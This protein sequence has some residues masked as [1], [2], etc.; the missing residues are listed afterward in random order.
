MYQF[1]LITTDT[2]TKTNEEISGNTIPS[3]NQST[4]KYSPEEIFDKRGFVVVRGLLDSSFLSLAFRYVFHSYVNGHMY[5]GDNQVANSPSCYGDALMESLLEEHLE[6]IEYVTNLKL[7]PTYSY[8][9]IYQSGDTLGKHKDRPA[10]EV[11]ATINLGSTNNKIEWPINVENKDGCQ[12]VFLKP[13]DALI[14]KGC[15]IP[16]WRDAFLGE[17]QAQVFLHYVRQDGPFADWKYDKRE[18]VDVSGYG[19]VQKNKK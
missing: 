11:S 2:N 4:T 3:S 8:F 7:Y 15:E 14:Y 9:R 1:D 10:C 18:L 6:S 12:S 19:L 17:L 13:G 5:T 16:H